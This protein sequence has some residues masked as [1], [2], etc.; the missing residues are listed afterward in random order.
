[1]REEKSSLLR[2]YSDFSQGLLERQT[3]IDQTLSAYVEAF[4][5][6]KVPVALF[7]FR[8]VGH[9]NIAGH[10]LVAEEIVS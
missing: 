8:R 9:Y 6:Q 1:M 5:A 3:D 4:Q 7:P 10:Q 2:R